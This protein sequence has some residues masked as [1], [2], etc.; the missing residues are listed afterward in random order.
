MPA[1]PFVYKHYGSLAFIGS[2]S[3]VSDFT[4]A[5]GFG[6]TPLYGARLRGALAWFVWRS[7]YLTKLGSWRNRVQV[8]WDWTRTLLFGRDTTQF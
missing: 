3:A 2:F 6:T 1:T 7:A 8:P 5:K 4:Q